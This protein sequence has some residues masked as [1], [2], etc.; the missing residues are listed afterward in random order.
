MPLIT[1]T[2]KGSKL[3]IAEMDGN[4]TYLDNKVPYKVYTVLLSQSGT[5][6][7]VATVLENTLGEEITWIRTD[8]GTYEANCSLLVDT[9]NYADIN[10]W[11]NIFGYN[12]INGVDSP[13]STTA[14]YTELWFETG[15]IKLT[16]VELNRD[17][18]SPI[19]NFIDSALYFLPIEIRVYN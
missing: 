10:T 12:I 19:S 8:V 11:T 15:V 16:T 2:G 17:G 6:D 5:D 13:N 4:L 1:R 18:S 14:K 7:P 9:E 3:T